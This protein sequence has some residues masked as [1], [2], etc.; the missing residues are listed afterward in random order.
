MWVSLWRGLFYSGLAEF[1]RVMPE[2]SFRIG[3]FKIIAYITRKSVNGRKLQI[4]S[5][6]FDYEVSAK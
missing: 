1:F 3:Q 5:V 2:L 4:N 6:V